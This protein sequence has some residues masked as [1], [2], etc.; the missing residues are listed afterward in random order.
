MTGWGQEGPYAKT[1]GHDI[2]YIS[3]AGALAH[4]GREGEPPVPPLNLVGDFGGGGMM[5]AFGMACGLLEA[6]G[7][8]QGQVIDCAMVDGAAL[9]MAPFHGML[10]AGA[11]REERGTNLLDSG[12]HFYDAYECADGK[13]ISL[14][15]IEPQFYAELLRCTGLSGDPAFAGQMDRTKWPSLKKRLREVIRGKTQAEWCSI[16]EGT[17]VCFAPVLPISEAYVHPHNTHRKTFMECGGVRQPSPGPRFS[18]TMPEVAGVPSV[19]GEHTDSV[20][21]DW[22]DASANDIVKLREAGAVR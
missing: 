15:S 1:A 11:M 20:L 4:I 8:G 3:L 10:A 13:Y 7:S 21:T 19:P 22:L 2:N 9:L 17:D 14:G 12:A 16:M 6:Q 5:L 18:R